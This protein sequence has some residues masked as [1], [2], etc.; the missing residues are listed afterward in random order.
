MTAEQLNADC[1]TY[2]AIKTNEVEKTR[3]I[4]ERAFGRA[5]IDEQTNEIR[6]YGANAET[7]AKYL[8]EN[9]DIAVGEIRTAKISLEEYY[10]D[11][12]QEGR[13]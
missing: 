12:M 13:K 8:F 2:V 5:D 11:L 4:L 1:P 7:V 10:I 9:F 3:A 6:V